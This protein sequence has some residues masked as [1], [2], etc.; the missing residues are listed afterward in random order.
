MKT[1]TPRRRPTVQRGFSLLEVLVAFSVLAIALGVLMRV[2]GGAARAAGV[3]EEY[4]RAVVAAE[5]LLADV[6]VVQPL[7]VGARE[8]RL[9][10]EFRWILRVAPYPVPGMEDS[11][12]PFRLYAVDVSVI[13]GEGE[14]G[15]PREVTLSSLR[16]V[17]EAPQPGG[18]L[19][20]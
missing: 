12:L 7:V 19:R 15:E 11:A 18:F 2:F 17:N 9:G 5:S 4:A 1:K 6:G 20:R 8:G 14:G 13:W 16:L 3:T 10:D